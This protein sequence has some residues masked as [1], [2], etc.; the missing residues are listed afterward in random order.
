MKKVLKRFNMNEARSVS[1]R[2]T[3]HFKLSKEQSLVTED[4]LAY[5]D[6]ISY[7]S[8]IKA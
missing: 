6:K 8:A 2:L 5:M 4:E 7:A 3:N 1:T